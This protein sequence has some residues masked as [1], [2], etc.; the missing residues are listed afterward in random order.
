MPIHT[1]FKQHMWV[2]TQACRP[3]YFVSYLL[4]LQRLLW[5]T[6]WMTTTTSI[7]TVQRKLGHIIQL[8]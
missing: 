1:H 4:S 3:S 8:N 7:A 6:T 5:R 2:Q